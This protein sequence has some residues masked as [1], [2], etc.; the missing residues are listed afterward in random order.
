MVAATPPEVRKARAFLR[1]KG[2]TTQEI[3]PRKFAS[4]AKEL[5]RGFRETLRFI[6]TAQE[7]RK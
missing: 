7:Q 3:P 5:D 6:I 2:I 1:S 4:A